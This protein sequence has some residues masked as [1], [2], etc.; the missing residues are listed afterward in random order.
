MTVD[1]I[2]K[3]GIPV[4]IPV[5]GSS[6]FPFMTTGDSIIVTSPDNLRKGDIIIFRDPESHDGGL[7]CHRII[8]IFRQR[9]ITFYITRGDALLYEDR[10]VSSDR[11]IGKVVRIERK[12]VSLPRRFF[13]LLNLF[14]RPRG[15]NALLLSIAYDLLERLRSL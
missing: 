6:M 4:R 2:I 8:R 14:M 13:L 9:E 15:L 1:P 5:R 7:I 11:V 12:K 10:P 3:Q